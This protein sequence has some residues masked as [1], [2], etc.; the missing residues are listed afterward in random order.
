MRKDKRMRIMVTAFGGL[1]LLTMLILITHL[2]SQALPLALTPKISHKMT[3]KAAADTRFIGS[4]DLG[5]GQPAM[6]STSQCAVTLALPEK[7]SLKTSRTFHHPCEHEATVVNLAGEHYL[8]TVSAS[9]LLRVS[10]LRGL[11]NPTPKSASIESSSTGPDMGFSFALNKARWQNRKSWDVQLSERWIVAT[12]TTDT[13][14]Y[15][16][17]I[18]Q[19]DPTRVFDQA[20]DKAQ[21]ILVLPNV[22]QLVTL[23]KE[24][25][26]F[27]DVEGVMLRTAAMP[28]DLVWWQSIAKNRTFFTA[29]EQGKVTRWV[30]YNDGGTLAFTPTYAF[31]I[32]SVPIAIAAHPSSNALAMII[33][34]K[35]LLLF[36]RLTGEQ[37]SQ[38]RM[39]VSASG[40]SWYADRLYLF[41]TET[42]ARYQID[43][44]SGVTT[45]E[46]LFSPQQYEGYAEPRHVWQTSSASDFQEQK[47][48]LSPL[49][50]GSLKASLLALLVAIPLSVGAAVYTGF[51]AR[52]R[53]R[54][55]VKPGIEM[56]EAIPS[57]LIGF[58]AAIWLSP[59]ATNMLFAIAFFLVTVPF[60]LVI[61]ALAQQ[62]LAHRTGDWPP[63]LE[64]LVAIIAILILGYASMVWAPPW[65]LNLLGET[66][67]AALT[68]QTQSPVGK[69]AVVV[70]IALG[71]AISPSIYTLTEDAIAGV[72]ADLKQA[73]FAL[74]ATRLQ[75]L[76]RV[77]LH[78]A[79]PGIL[80]ATM[81]GF[82]RAF[83]ETMIVLMVTG[84]TPIASWDL[85]EG[86]RAL[87]A[88]LT[89]ELPEADVGS[90]HYQILFFTA[91]ILF[92]FTFLVNTVA[93]LL[94]QRLRRHLRYE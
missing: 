78:V 40:I 79:T 84:N 42:L 2:I 3:Y 62:Y 66:H 63:G 56:L 37:V 88:N 1:V 93:E 80:A 51:F 18:D 57:V 27:Y 74:G 35:Q 61:A 33:E 70:A 21:P 82:G 28:Q 53:L 75:T 49:L 43:Y 26:S 10:G 25:L 91:C 50:I 69:T 7:Q 83:G 24:N 39:P 11:N 81:F 19:S 90:T 38:I 46:S 58:I 92:G 15:V 4:G 45:W 55:L 6:L 54:Q 29:S 5:E 87:T 41:S 72:P 59:L 17:W 64:L 48:S 36:N 31:F 13:H 86:L 47:Y 71:I 30:L 20:F 89:I 9:G 94:R 73:S 14:Q 8:V 76:R 32:D 44:L 77:V 67:I 60:V 23:S 65:I 68:T 52:S 22:G 12:I 85:L 34:S 16:R